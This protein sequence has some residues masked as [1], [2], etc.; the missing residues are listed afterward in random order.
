VFEAFVLNEDELVPAEQLQR[1]LTQ[2]SFGVL[3]A[4]GYVK[5]A[6][7]V[8]CLLQQVGSRSVLTA[9]DGS[10]VRGVVVIGVKHSLDVAGIQKALLAIRSEEA[11]AF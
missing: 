1:L 2:P 7:G 11:V 3:R 6:N 5:R 10:I 9:G 4:K 8:G